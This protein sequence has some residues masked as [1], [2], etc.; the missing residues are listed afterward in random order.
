METKVNEEAWKEE[1]VYGRSMMESRR[2]NGRRKRRR[3]RKKE[4]KKENGP[5][6][7]GS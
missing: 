7:Y 6:H 1:E 4:V 5:G 2:R 3:N